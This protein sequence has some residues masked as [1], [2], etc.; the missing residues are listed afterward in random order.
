MNSL[1]S[2][3][4]ATMFQGSIPALVTPMHADGA[5]D[6]VALQQLV[7]WHIEAGSSAVVVCGTTGESATLTLNEQKL[8]VSAALEASDGQ[9]PVI[10]GTGSPDTNK[11]IKATIQAEALG[12]AG[13]LIVTPY[14]LKT[15]QQGL[16]EH[17]KAI[18][19]ETTLPIILYNVPGR[20]TVDLLPETAIEL[21]NIEHIVGIKEATGET[22]RISAIKS[23]VPDFIVLSGD[24][25]SACEAMQHG[26][27]GVISVTSNIMPIQM[28]AMCQAIAQGEVEQAIAINQQIA[29]VHDALFVEPNPI[30]VKY[31]LCQLGKIQNHLRLPLVPLSQ[32]NE[33]I[34]MNAYHGATQ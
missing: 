32:E 7:T 18:A 12:A 16:I 6:L 28:A 13:A 26:A 30:P 8:I 5:I 10:V 17:F 24:D 19:N 2:D 14:Y 25:P 34:I 15:T 21:A 31:V 29:H 4:E 3:T 9:I 22:R 20:T 33:S 1:L 11:A 23:A 27:D